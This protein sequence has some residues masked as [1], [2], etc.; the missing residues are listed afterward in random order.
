MPSLCARAKVPEP[1][2]PY[3]NLTWA[4][5]QRRADH[6]VVNVSWNDA[7]AYIAW[8]VSA[9]GQRGWRLPTEAEWEKS[10]ALGSGARTPASSTPGVI[11]F[12]KSPLQHF[13]ERHREDHACWLVPRP[14]H[15]S[16]RRQSKEVEEMAGNV[17][18]WTGSAFKP[19]PY[20]VN[21]GSEE[22]KIYWEIERC[23]AARG[24]TTPGS[25]AAYRYVSAPDDLSISRGFRLAFAP[26]GAGS[27]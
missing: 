20:I 19:Y 3:N 10:G 25:R 2:S 22:L 5:Q 11:I 15:A 26:A 13:R 24:S 4:E 12:D 18:E 16:F 17:W 7:M 8:L 9:T 1:K 6:P 21:D 27:S 23:V 14:R